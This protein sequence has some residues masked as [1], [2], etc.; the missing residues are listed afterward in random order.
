[1]RLDSLCTA[2]STGGVRA[3][4]RD[5]NGKPSVQ[6]DQPGP[7][8]LGL[9]RPTAWTTTTQRPDDGSIH[10][11]APGWLILRKTS[12][13]SSS[14]PC[15]RPRAALRSSRVPP[16]ASARST[17]WAATALARAARELDAVRARRS[18][19]AIQARW[20][21]H[22]PRPCSTWPCPR[23]R[24]R[25]RGVAGPRQSLRTRRRTKLAFVRSTTTP[26]TTVV[27][28]ARRRRSRAQAA[29]ARQ[30]AVDLLVRL[31]LGVP[32]PCSAPLPR[33][34]DRA[35]T[36]G[37]QLHDAPVSAIARR[38]LPRSSSSRSTPSQCRRL[39][40]LAGDGFGLAA[41]REHERGAGP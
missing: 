25:P 13:S 11:R 8:H 1:M 9:G 32:L 33:P 27:A 19:S 7:Q 15:R 14:R 20:S 12:S 26:R 10:Q 24:R 17:A 4:Q 21:R 23:S 30:G 31:P 2:P 35:A 41:R 28:H 3:R 5:D 18:P 29:A 22:R 36:P 16:C 39:I 37:E 40:D 6:I 38:R 34:S